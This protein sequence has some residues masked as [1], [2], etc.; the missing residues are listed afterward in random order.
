MKNKPKRIRIRLIV[1]ALIL[2]I[3]LNLYYFWIKIGGGIFL[4]IGIFEIV[5]FILTIISI[6]SLIIRLIKNISWRY[7]ANYLTLGFGIVVIASLGFHQLRLGEDSFQSDVKLRA[8]YEGT[9]NTSHLLFRENGTFEDYNIGWFAFVH[10]M[11]GT[12]RQNSDT[13]FLDSDNELPFSLS[14]TILVTDDL[15]LN[16]KNDTIEP[17][18]YYWGYCKGLN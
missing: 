12:W 9:M 14:D 5:S 3:S 8:C 16:V 15:I 1:S 13:I 6:I 7:R 17:S 10:Y 4:I 18:Y 11:N 2:W